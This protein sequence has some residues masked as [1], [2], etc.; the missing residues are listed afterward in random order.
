[1]GPRAREKSVLIAIA[2]LS[3]GTWALLIYYWKVVF[4]AV[5][6]LLIAISP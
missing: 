4:F 1:M 2:A 3:V 5:V 6:M